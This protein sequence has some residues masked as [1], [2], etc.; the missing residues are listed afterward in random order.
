MKL[1]EVDRTMDKKG[2]LLKYDGFIF[3]PQYVV[4]E[5]QVLF[6]YLHM[7]KAFKRGSNIADDP[8]IEFLVRL[9]GKDQ[10]STAIKLGLKDK[11]ERFGVLMPDKNGISSIKGDPKKIKEFFGTTNKK[12][13]F[14][15]IALIEVL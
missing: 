14:E 12:E 13:I 1:F 2:I 10:I 7:K 6:A 4:D 9:S 15:K 5:E 8:K 3:D 11:M